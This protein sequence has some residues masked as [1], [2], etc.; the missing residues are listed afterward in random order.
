[1]THQLH[2]HLPQGRLSHLGIKQLPGNELLVPVVEGHIIMW[3]DTTERMKIRRRRLSD[4][5]QLGLPQWRSRSV[6]PPHI[7]WVDAAELRALAK[8]ARIANEQDLPA[9][10]KL[11]ASR[12]GLSGLW[13]NGPAAFMHHSL[14]SQ[15]LDELARLLDSFA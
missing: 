4:K 12:D 7:E 13:F 6:E 3:P 2:H 9:H 10:F 8:A 11:R 15:T 5:W 14:T 1:M